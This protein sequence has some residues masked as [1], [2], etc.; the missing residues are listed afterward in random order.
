MKNKIIIKRNLGFFSD[1]LTSIAGIMYCYDNDKDFYVDW[2]NILYTNDMSK[3]L[4]NEFFYQKSI[5]DGNFENTFFNVTPYGYY[6]PNNCKTNNDFYDLYEKPAKIMSELNIINSTFI[7]SINKS[8]FNNKKVLGVHKRGT[9]HHVHGELLK[10]EFYIENI[11]NELKNN[12][13][14]KIFLI[15]DEESTSNYFKNVYG[16]MLITTDSFKSPNNYPIHSSL[17]HS[18][19]NKEKLAE[20]V[21]KDA[22]LLS[23]CDFKIVTRSNVSSFSLMCDLQKDNFNYIDLHIKQK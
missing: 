23:L 15:T 19:S 9:D 17:S 8:I 7:N 10:N 16:D 13:Y 12:S 20:D 1:F 2:K 11:N 14:D 3:N 4:Y 6:F 18:F 22:I 21:I 5:D